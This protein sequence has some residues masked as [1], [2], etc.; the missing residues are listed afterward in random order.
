[1]ILYNRFPCKWPEYAFHQMEI[2]FNELYILIAVPRNASSRNTSL[3]RNG[4]SIA[5]TSNT[6]VRNVITGNVS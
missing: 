6:L 3:I 5:L 4:P 2:R 1:M